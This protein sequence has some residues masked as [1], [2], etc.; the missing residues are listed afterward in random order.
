MFPVF[1]KPWLLILLLLVPALMWQWRRRTWGQLRFSS[2]KLQALPTGRG[3]R[4]VLVGTGLRAAALVLLIVALAG[5]RWPDPGSRIATHGIAIAMV[6]D[7]SGS[8]ASQDYRW[9]GDP[10]GRLDAVK[11]AFRLMVEGGVGP[12]GEELPGRPDDLIELIA[13]ATRPETACPLTL[14]H[15][16]L[17]KILDGQQ[18]RT[19][20]T[21]ATTNTGDAIAWA[22]ESLQRAPVK[23]KVLVLL[24]DGEHN[25]PSPALKP[26]QAAQLA[27]NLGIPIYAIHA[28]NE[29]GEDGKASEEAAR[30]R[31]SLEDVARISG[32]KYF[33][34][35]DTNSLLTACQDID[36]LEKV[37]IPSFHYRL[38]YEGFAWFA[39]ASL[40]GW[41]A[42]HLL[43]STMW[44]RVP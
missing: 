25:V 22:V 10:I 40:A 38:Y 17:L 39:L 11:H 12:D 3:R 5:P 14:N 20:I 16:V 34:A 33:Q 44:R 13:Y 21:E 41:L 8:M 18:P 35:G 24:S 19:L 36:R 32:G 28:G 15:H 6:V 30:A 42:L 2:S 26:R 4:A 37:E 1:S 27:G 23:R 29:T 31:Q 9:K 43:E 7:V